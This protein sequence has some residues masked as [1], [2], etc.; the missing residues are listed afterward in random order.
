[1]K[2]NMEPS[3]GRVCYFSGE[4]DVLPKCVCVPSESE[5]KVSRDDLYI[6][7]LFSLCFLCTFRNENR[8]PKL[9]AEFTRV[10]ILDC[11]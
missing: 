1:M 8:E 4:S 9:D 10:D 6:S 11:V 2:S 3:L 7:H 5:N